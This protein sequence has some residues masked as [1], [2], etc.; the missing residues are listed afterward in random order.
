MHRDCNI[1]LQLNHKIAVIFH[2]LKKFDSHLIWQ[3]LGKFSLKINVIPNGL[4]KYMNFNINNKLSFIDSFQFLSS[5]LKSL[6]K[7]LSNHDFKYLSQEFDNNLL[8]LVKQKRFYP[9]EYVGDSEKF[10][11]ELSG[12]EKFYSSL[13]N[14]KI[15]DKEY[16]HVLNV[17]NK[18]E[19]KTM[20][21]RFIFS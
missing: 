14:R 13:S 7:N 17:W 19:M 10:K 2:N 1:N 12:K 11:E 8:D 16:E 21:R 6:V 20:K 5:S 3:E 4:E 9:Y 15:T 18:F